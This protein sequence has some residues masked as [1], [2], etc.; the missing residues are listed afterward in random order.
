MV[1]IFSLSTMTTLLY[2]HLTS[3]KKIDDV[4]MIEL[5][6]LKIAIQ[7]QIGS[8]L[9]SYYV[10]AASGN[11][12]DSDVNQ[13]IE[14][15]KKLEKNL[16]LHLD[17]SNQ[18]EEHC[19]GS[20]SPVC[21]EIY[22]GNLADLPWHVKAWTLDDNCSK[23]IGHL[24]TIIS[25]ENGFEEQT[26]RSIKLQY[27][28]V[29]ILKANKARCLKITEKVLFNIVSEANYVYI[30]SGQKFMKNAKNGPFWRVFGNL[31]LAVKKCYQTGKF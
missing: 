31:K 6:L 4:E 20:N 12:D 14:N 24:L 3:R 28:D 15:L 21:D 11:A 16:D 30:L 2:I 19:D 25:I 17:L 29:A 7:K 5:H 18:D 1:L 23:P 22:H 13:L 9:E 27:P 26:F 10:A 8:I